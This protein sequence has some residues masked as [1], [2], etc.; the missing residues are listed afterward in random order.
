MESKNFT[1]GIESLLLYVELRQSLQVQR[2][3]DLPISLDCL[4]ALV[5]LVQL[6][7]VQA[8]VPEQSIQHAHC[9]ELMLNFL[10]R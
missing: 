9:N 5:C 7:Q 6:D 2:A 10:S 8:R 4:G 3:I 1:N